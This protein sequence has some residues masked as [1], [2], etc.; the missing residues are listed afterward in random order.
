MQ[1][2]GYKVKKQYAVKEKQN[3]CL[4]ACRKMG[5]ELVVVFEGRKGR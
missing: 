5:R 1:E 2:K 3:S 4:D